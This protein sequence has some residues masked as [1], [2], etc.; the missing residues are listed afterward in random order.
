MVAYNTM[1]MMI[2]I[3]IMIMMTML[4]KPLVKGHPKLSEVVAMVTGVDEVCIVHLAMLVTIIIRFFIMLKT[5]PTP[6][7]SGQPSS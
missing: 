1:A 7:P 3:M 2:M 6:L 4:K 5:P